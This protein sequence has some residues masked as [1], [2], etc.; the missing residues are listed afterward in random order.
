[1]SLIVDE[2]SVSGLR[3]QNQSLS[4][5]KRYQLPTNLQTWILNSMPARL[6]TEKVPRLETDK[7][8]ELGRKA[9]HGKG[10]IENFLTAFLGRPRDDVACVVGSFGPPV[11]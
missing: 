5:S 1:M 8:E 4:R 7:G 3:E 9:E 6:E 10:A 2:K 11:G